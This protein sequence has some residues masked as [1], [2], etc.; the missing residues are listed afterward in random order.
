MEQHLLK[1]SYFKKAC[2]HYSC[3]A[4]AFAS[5][6]QIIPSKI[7]QNESIDD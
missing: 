7:I 4:T 2:S 3:R 1:A 5:L 6:Q